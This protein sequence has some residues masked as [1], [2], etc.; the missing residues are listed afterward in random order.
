LPIPWFSRQTGGSP[1]PKYELRSKA[2]AG[3]RARRE[4]HRHQTVFTGASQPSA[5]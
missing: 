3:L 2:E 1:P 4:T 5:A